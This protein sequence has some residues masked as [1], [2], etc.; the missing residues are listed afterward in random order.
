M[1]LV[2]RLYRMADAPELLPLEWGEIEDLAKFVL[3]ADR[4]E[5]LL[6]LG[7][8]ALKEGLHEGRPTLVKAGRLV[9]EEARRWGEKRLSAR[10]EREEARRRASRVCLGGLLKA[11]L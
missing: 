8:A 2:S 10:Q 4:P 3:A 9:K 11:A 6:R 7:E 5:A 1:T